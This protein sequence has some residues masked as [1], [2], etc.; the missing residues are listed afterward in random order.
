VSS[1]HFSGAGVPAPARGVYSHRDGGQFLVQESCTG[2]VGFY[3]HSSP[4]VCGC[5][6]G[7]RMVP[8]FAAS[9]IRLRP[10]VSVMLAPPRCER[11]P[12]PLLRL[13]RAIAPKRKVH[14]RC[15]SEIRHPL[16]CKCR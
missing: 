4:S 15:F 1:L 8:P 3:T 9:D 6:S 14:M 11:L 7:L 2:P 13:Q 16:P 12:V 10:D 5:S